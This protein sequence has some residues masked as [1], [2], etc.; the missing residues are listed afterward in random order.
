MSYEVLGNRFLKAI[1]ITVMMMNE[2][3]TRDV[4]NN[5]QIPIVNQKQKSLK[6]IH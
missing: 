3:F 1:T 6:K 2:T 4:G 5:N